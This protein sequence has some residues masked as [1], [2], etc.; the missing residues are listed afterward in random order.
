[1]CLLKKGIPFLWDESI[2]W[3]FDDL[4]CSLISSLVLQPLE[5]N[6][7]FL[8]YLASYDST[9]GMVLVQIEDGHNEHVI[10]YLSKDL[11]GAKFRYLYVEKLAPEV[12]SA[13]Q[14]FQHYILMRTTIVISKAH[15]MHCILS[16][17]ILGGRYSKWIV[18]L[19]EFDL[20]F[21][22]PKAKK[23]MVF[24]V[25]FPNFPYVFEEIVPLYSFP[26][27]SL[28]LIDS[29]DLWYGDTLIYLQIQRFQTSASKDD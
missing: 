21:V 7:D 8:W 26:D 10:Y 1:M 19:Q 6:Q 18:M 12:V 9:I 17:Q 25:L 28:F 22:T 5:Y 15:P 11:V 29:F 4:K 2:Q 16:R 13:V 27:E 14:Q 23:C 24:A 3:P 20:E